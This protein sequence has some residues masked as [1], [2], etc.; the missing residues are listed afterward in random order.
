MLRDK[1]DPL[2]ERRKQRQARLAEQA[3]VVTFE[4]CAD[5]YIK[6]HGDGWSARHLQVW[7]SSLRKYVFG[8][9][10]KLA[11]TDIDFGNRNE[12]HRADLG[13]EDSDGIPRARPHRDGLGLRENLRLLQRR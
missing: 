8:K 5:L 10:G 7:K 12:G 9:I 4:K 2:T 1:I 3:K 6:L 11:P 13:S